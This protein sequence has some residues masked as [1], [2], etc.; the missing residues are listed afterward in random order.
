MQELTHGTMCQPLFF[1]RQDK[2][3]RSGKVV[4]DGVDRLE[5]DVLNDIRRY[6]LISPGDHVIAAVS[7]GADSVCCLRVLYALREEIPV[8]LSVVHVEHGL[9]GEA[10]LEDAAFVSGLC[11]RLGLACRT[12]HVNVRREAAAGYSVEEAAR[13]LRYRCLEKVRRELGADRIASAH[14]AQDQ[15]ETVLFHLARGSGIRGGGGMRR[16]QG[17]V[18]RPLLDVSPGQIRDYLHRIGQDWREDATNASDEYARNRIRHQVLPGLVSVNDRAVEHICENAALLQRAEDFIAGCAGELTG[19]AV[20]WGYTPE[21]TGRAENRG[22]VPELSKGA[23][24]SGYAAELRGQAASG[25]RLPEYAVIDL[26]VA[27]SS[28]RLLKEY[29]I[30]EVLGRL[31]GGRGLKDITSVH[32]R[33]IL[34][35]ENG[36]CGRE[37]TL[38]GGLHAV[39][40]KDAVRIESCRLS[41]SDQDLPVL[42]AGGSDRLLM[43]A[44]DQ[45]GRSH[46]T[47]ADT[48]GRP[49]PD[50]V[51]VTP[52]LCLKISGEEQIFKLKGLAGFENAPVRIHIR[53]SEY[54]VLQTND[55]K[56]PV[57]RTGGRPL[58]ISQ[59]KYTKILAY[60]T[61]NGELCLRTRR[62]GDYL[63]VNAGG[64]RKKLK[65]YMINEKIPARIRDRV[66]LLA[67]GSHILW[68]IGWR[69]SEA[70]KVTSGSGRLLEITVE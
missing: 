69:I 17:Y 19:R 64:G 13:L 21:L 14:H 4:T 32:I 37:I 33:E 22:Y 53:A 42:T 18:I 16:I 7:G 63:V 62:S 43:Q 41:R 50:I 48:A 28:D 38:P 26:N 29:M 40:E 11:S 58:D 45:A 67:Q 23:E 24:N 49:L 36:D 35:L 27:G 2:P 9:R 56:P 54:T 8:R 47:A 20:M 3:E 51:Q 68:V 30:R 12:E 70:A 10:S 1:L 57:V 34:A 60:D 65:D 52:E 46:T 66:L 15:A 25:D 39:R 31:R 59:K 44:A 61:I 6:G 5:Q 55:G